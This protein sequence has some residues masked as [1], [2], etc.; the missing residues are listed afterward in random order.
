MSSED[1]IH[2]LLKEQEEKLNFMFKNISSILDNSISKKILKEKNI[3]V[4]KRNGSRII[5]AKIGKNSDD[6]IEYH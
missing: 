2:P 1:K 6:N 4:E 5:R 3:I